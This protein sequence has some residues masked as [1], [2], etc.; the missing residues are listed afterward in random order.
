MRVSLLR[1]ATTL[2]PY[3]L[4]SVAVVVASAI[5]LAGTVRH[6]EPEAPGVAVVSPAP[7]AAARRAE[8]SDQRMAYWRQA[9]SG[10]LE[11]W[12]SDLDGGR[13]WTIATAAGDADV[14]LTRW[15]PDGSA[16]AYRIAS[17]T[18]GIMRLDGT[19]ASLV[20]PQPQRQARWRIA[21]YEWSL[22]A[23]RIAATFRAGGGL[24]N[25]SDVWVASASTNAVWERVTTLGDAYAGQWI[26]EHRLFVESSSGLIAVLD[27]RTKDLRPV[28]AVPSVSPQIQRDGRVWFIGGGAV[29]A[30]VATQPVATGWVWSATIDGGGLRKEVTAEHGQ[31]RLF[32]VLAD[33]RPVIGVPGGVYVAGEGLVPLVFAGSGSVR[34]V[35]VSED[36]RRVLGLTDSRILR[37]EPTRIPRILPPAQLP[38]TDAATTLLSGIK[39]PDI[40]TAR[41]PVEAART[42]ATAS[43]VTA[44]TRTA[45]TLGHAVWE[46]LPDGSAKAIVTERGTL[47]GRPVWSPSGDRFALTYVEIGE[48]QPSALVVGPGGPV[49]WR[50]PT[51]ADGPVW[52]PDGGAVAFWIPTGAR[53]DQWNTHT[54]DPATGRSIDTSPGRTVWAGGARVVLSDGEFEISGGTAAATAIRVAQKVEV[55]SGTARRALTDAR[56]LASSAALR[57]VPDAARTP[58]ITAVAATSD[59][60]HVMVTLARLG[61]QQGQTTRT[62]THVIVRLSDGEPVHVM[63]IPVDVG[64]SDLAWSPAAFA[65][66]YGTTE[67]VPATGALVRSAVIV[68]PL[69]AAVRFKVDGR[70]A[71]WSADG[72][73][74]YVARDDGLYAYRVGMDGDPVRVSPLGAIVSAAPKR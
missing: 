60:G 50:L 15:A 71:G 19:I 61:A 35:F 58:L 31:A 27:L 56:T 48:R 30:D 63:P 69:A 38:P 49:R 5:A 1:T 42:T 36:G 46:L 54:F 11:L 17:A 37:I 68:D 3:A 41:R 9:A 34:R 16:V 52:S 33:N 55:V 67:V 65:L 70:F 53:L 7:A 13:R 10:S 64:P 6:A 4:A 39:E 8:L 59:P 43:T 47:N 26:D 28:T 45:F 14:G 72:A 23:K 29:T 66:G 44:S 32:G 20:M 74:A 18:I 51:R 24:S 73:W 2:L 25:E 40:W 21:N 62:P 12:V 57:G 22:D